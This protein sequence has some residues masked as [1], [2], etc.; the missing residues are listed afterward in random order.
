[1]ELGSAQAFLVALLLCTSVLQGQGRGKLRRKH[2]SANVIDPLPSACG[3]LEA[4]GPPHGCP[5]AFI[6][7][8]TA[9][10]PLMRRKGPSED[11]SD[12]GDPEKSKGERQDA[13]KDG[14]TASAVVDDTDVDQVTVFFY[15]QDPVKSIHFSLPK[16]R[17]RS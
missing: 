1:M 5:W 8:R 11:S 7:Q 3:Q 14:G 9:R 4:T 12:G 13:A 10:A 17:L 2:T 15:T 6:L 16:T